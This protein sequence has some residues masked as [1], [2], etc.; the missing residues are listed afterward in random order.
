MYRPL[1]SIEKMNK[2]ELI[3]S[4][5]MLHTIVCMLAAFFSSSVMWAQCKG[6][7]LNQVSLTELERPCGASPTGKIALEIKGGM[8]PYHLSWEINGVVSTSLPKTIEKS[9]IEIENLRGTSVPGYVV[10]VTDACEN[11]MTSN[12]LNLRNAPAIQFVSA[13]L[14]M[15]PNGI[16]LV[17]LIGGISPRTLLVTD[18]KGRA[19]KQQI[20]NGPPEN[21]KFK[22]EVKNLPPETYEIE[23]QSASK[24]CKQKWTEIIVIKEFER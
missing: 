9:K 8:A 5:L 21:G 22:Y 2:I 17:E 7:K 6:V 23:I 11:Q 16:I 18:S 15:Q 1:S 12:A 13:P 4:Q 19:Y 3:R 14:I 20:P 24:N 10:S